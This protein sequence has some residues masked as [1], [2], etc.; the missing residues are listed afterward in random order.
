MYLSRL[1]TCP[2]YVNQERKKLSV[3]GLDLFFF[4]LSGKSILWTKIKKYIYL[5]NFYITEVESDM[6]AFFLV[7]LFF[8]F[9]FSFPAWILLFKFFFF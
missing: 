3:L 6:R 2:Y 9:F 8:F 7:Y 1:Y 4:P 5:D